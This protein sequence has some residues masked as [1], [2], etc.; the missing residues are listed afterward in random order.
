MIRHGRRLFF[1]F[2]PQKGSDGKPAGHAAIKVPRRNAYE[3]L[4][5]RKPPTLAKA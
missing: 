4:G 3:Y 1:G 2:S 5:L